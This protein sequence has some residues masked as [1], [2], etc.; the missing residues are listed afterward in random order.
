MR[1]SSINGPFSIAMLNYQRVD[2]YQTAVFFAEEHLVGRQPSSL[3]SGRSTDRFFGMLRIV[4]GKHPWETVGFKGKPWH[5]ERPAAVGWSLARS[6]HRKHLDIVMW[7]WFFC[8]RCDPWHFEVCAKTF[9]WVLNNW[10]TPPSKSIN[11][12]GL[13]EVQRLLDDLYDDLSTSLTTWARWLNI[14]L[15]VKIQ[16]TG[17]DQAGWRVRVRICDWLSSSWLRRTGMN[18]DSWLQELAKP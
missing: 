6:I 11:S 14:A 8:G 5:S 4:A 18:W 13:R 12:L 7:L 9:R 10:R 2:P 17:V 3:S 16:L 15:W 1:K